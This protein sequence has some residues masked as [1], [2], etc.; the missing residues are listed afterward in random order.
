MIAFANCLPA[1]AQIQ[2]SIVNPSF[3]LPFTGT[4]SAALNPFLTSTNW[5]SVDSGEILG[6]ETTHP[7]QAN[8]CP[9]G[10]GIT[11]A[12]NCT[13]IELW[14][15]SF[16]GVVPAQGV[17]LAEL[18]AY[19]SSK[20]FQNICMNNGEVF[21]F[22]FAH[23]GRSGIDQAQF[24][25]GTSTV[26][27]DVSTGTSTTGVINAGGGASGTSATGIAG[28]WT[29]YAGS[30]TYTGA[31]G[32]QALG[33]AAISAAGGIAQGNLLDDI[34]IFLKPYATFPSAVTSVV[35]GNTGTLPQIKI[36]GTVPP[37]GLT[38]SMAVSGSAVF[39]TDFNYTGSTTLVSISGTSVTLNVTVP[40]G[41]Y[42]DVLANNIFTLPLNIFNDSVIG[43]NKTIILSSLP[44]GAGSNFINANVT[45]CGGTFN[46][47]VTHTIIDNDIDLRVTKS[48]TASGTLTAGS[49]VFYTLSFANITPAV[50]TIAPLTAH[51]AATVTI[52][53]LAPVGIVL[54]AWTCTASGTSCPTAT[55][56]GA[57]S[58]TV[59]L[60]VGAGLIYQLQATLGTSTLC[61]QN[62]TNTA[63]VGIAAR[64]PSGANLAEG[65]SVQ[66]N[67]GYVFQT[68]TA[69]VSHLVA[70]C[71][72]LA[73]SK[74]NAANTVTSGQNT[75]Y[76]LVI[77]NT[78]PAHADNALLKDPVTPGLSCTNVV[79]ASAT[80]G[81][82]CASVSVINLALLQSSGIAL[83]NF[84]ANSS[85]TFDVACG[86]TATGL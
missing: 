62:V 61:L 12:Y 18:N 48:T 47:T 33:F 55:G 26:V 66:G 75:T 73:I 46:N 43:D 50:L 64:S 41:N 35:E 67:P 6:W 19:V 68:N 77:S 85:Y 21:T 52:A 51:D 59:N 34:N 57:I 31:S 38:M 44:N 53:D 5:I 7:I 37:G 20:L 69:S 71:V 14:A 58:Q 79:C 40:A 29:R 84:P 3:E 16:L 49:T 1:H 36:V 13:P 2:R 74:T 39:N 4:R 9:A 72:N 83:N 17:V 60:P 25:L 23:R 22:N 24:Q 70:S 30:Y 76:S 81:A 10:G 56:S 82:S 54:G 86:V 32:V 11:P 28:G 63:A 78:G 8:G 45:I 80:G 27:L 42:T 15:N 65:T